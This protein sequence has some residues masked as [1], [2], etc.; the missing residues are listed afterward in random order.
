MADDHLNNLEKLY[1]GKSKKVEFQ[2]EEEVHRDLIPKLSEDLQKFGFDLIKPFG[3]GSTATV[4]TVTDPH[5]GQERALKLPRPRLGKLKNIISVI[6][7]EREHLSS[8]T[9]QNLIKVYVA[10][11]IQTTVQNE[12]YQFPYFS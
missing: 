6:R 1:A 9:H 8:F 11:E 12:E 7:T 5:L 3:L 4:W 10:G 2:A